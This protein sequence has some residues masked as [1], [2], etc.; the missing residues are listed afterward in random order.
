M[1]P[2]LIVAWNEPG[3]YRSVNMKTCPTGRT[4]DQHQPRILCLPKPNTNNEPTH[5]AC[6]TCFKEILTC[7]YMSSQK[8]INISQKLVAEQSVNF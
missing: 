6:S 1:L 7:T 5:V 2:V 4:A 8:S 3:L